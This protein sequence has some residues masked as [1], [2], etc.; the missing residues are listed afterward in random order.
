[1]SA[2]NSFLKNAELKAIMTFYY[3]QRENEVS[4]RFERG[5]GMQRF[6]RHSTRH[7]MGRIGFL[8]ASTGIV[9]RSAV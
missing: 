2:K 5:V 9:A 1:M 8:S 7:V 6:S 4:V 3:L